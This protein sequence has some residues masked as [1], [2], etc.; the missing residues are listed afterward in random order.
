MMKHFVYIIYSS[1]TDEYYK[2]Y[3]QNPSIRLIDHNNAK[4]RYTSK[5]IPWILVYTKE[6]DTKSLALIE[7]KRLKKL[8]RKSIL[9]LIQK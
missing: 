2:G 1:S 5:G 6:F 3:S 4:S 8:N 7:E 9:E